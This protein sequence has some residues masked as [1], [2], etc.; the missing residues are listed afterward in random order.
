MHIEVQE[1]DAL[2]VA[3]IRHY[4]PYGLEPTQR[5]LKRLL[6]WAASRRLLEKPR[7]LGIPWNNPKVTPH[8]ECC[9]DACLVVEPSFQSDHP[10]IGVQIIPGGR[11]LV[12][13]CKAESGDLETPWQELLAWYQDS[14][15]EI[16]D[17][18]CFEIYADESYLD[19]NGNWSM[20][21]FMPVT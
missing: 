4:G 5:T 14:P 16:A 8:N 12:R 3:Y 11:Y 9:Y 20:Q 17:G 7:V 21:L 10:S 1:L 19:A 18:P 2:Q 15:W 6:K 13:R